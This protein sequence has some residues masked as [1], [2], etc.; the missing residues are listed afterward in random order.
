MTNF[1]VSNPPV[2]RTS[3]TARPQRGAT[4]ASNAP[5]NQRGSAPAARPLLLLFGTGTML[6]AVGGRWDIAATA[7]IFPVLLLRFTR[8]SRAWTGALWIWLAHIAAAVFWIQESAIGLNPVSA[9]GAA[10]LA[11]LQTLPFLADRLLVN[12]L[13]PAVAA[14]AFPAAVAG[15]E[16]LITVLS[17]FGTAYG[18][19]AVTQYG[20]LPL[21]QIIS[22][23]GSWGIGFLIAYFASTVNRIW[24]RPSWRSGLVYGAVLLTVVLTGS[25][26]LAFS[27]STST[28]VRIAGVSPGRTV[29]DHLKTTL[30]RITGG[31]AGI[32][33]AP[34]STVEPAM[35][36]VEND[37][38]ASTRREA[39]AGA[40][41]V[42]WPEEGVKTQ[43]AHESAAITDAQEQARRSGVYLEIGLRVYSTTAPAYGRDEAIL[44]DPHGKVL[45][46]YQKA[47]PIPGS[48]KFTPGDG[49]VP[50]ADTPYG[51][52]ANV[53]CYDADFPAMMRT[54]ADIMLV[55]SHDWKAFG[56]AHTMKA[57]LRA[58]EGGYSVVRQDAEGVSTAYDNKGQALA[59]TDYFTTGRQTVVAYVPTHGVTTIYDRIGDLFAWLCLAGV[60]A[61]TVTAVARPWRPASATSRTGT[62]HSVD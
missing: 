21:L 43:E 55:P 53:I 24:E 3:P 12:R 44:I 49:H 41:I 40:K 14:L 46:T 58:I 17:P 34:A 54:R 13:R 47:H 42:V 11:A 20:D 25:A 51:R 28:T 52:I 8:L 62:G 38:L 26:R 32:A 57:S 27:P 9:A 6:F 7:W 59:T 5:K 37:L 56:G 39:A 61:L 50:V 2:G 19:L 10:A 23:T 18:S 30:G 35:T 29:T 22:V 15:G 60:A 45:W 33:A 36:A 31:S 16:F 48:E 4:N 1:P